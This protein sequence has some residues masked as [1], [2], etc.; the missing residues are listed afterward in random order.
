MGWE[1]MTPR[2]ASQRAGNVCFMAPD[3]KAVT[4]SLE[5][6]GVLIWGAYAGVGRL[7]ISTHL[8]NDISDVERCLAALE[9][10]LP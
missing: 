4:D 6:Q 2:D 10:I 1:M 3:V 8:Y 9:T 5:K 7:R